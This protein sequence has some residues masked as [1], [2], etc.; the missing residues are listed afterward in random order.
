MHRTLDKTITSSST[1]QDTLT[2]LRRTSMLSSFS[3]S[4]SISRAARDTNEPPSIASVKYG[5]ITNDDDNIPR[6]SAQSQPSSFS[7]I[8]PT[9][10]HD[11]SYHN[12]ETDDSSSSALRKMFPVSK[13]DEFNQ[14][15]ESDVN[16]D[17]E[18]VEIVDVQLKDLKSNI[19]ENLV[20]EERRS[21]IENESDSYSDDVIME[22]NDK[23]EKPSRRF[24][25]QRRSNVVKQNREGSLFMSDKGNGTLQRNSIFG[26]VKKDESADG[27]NTTTLGQSFRHMLEKRPIAQRSRM[28]SGSSVL[29][30]VSDDSV[31]DDVYAG[32]STTSVST[33]NKRRVSFSERSTD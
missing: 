6:S 21:T 31:S 20:E 2:P 29:S 25:T 23:I 7:K 14:D 12:H 10:F 5:P 24:S 28:S 19:D 11:R 15:T 4:T 16:A 30:G 17:V 27:Q 18:A 1:Q 8:S 9:E 3:T 22:M 13:N 32:I 26:Q 33:Q